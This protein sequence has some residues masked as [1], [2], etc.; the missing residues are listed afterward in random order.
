[1]SSRGPAGAAKPAYCKKIKNK[2]KR[3]KHLK[4]VSR[5]LSLKATIAAEIIPR[6]AARDK[7]QQLRGAAG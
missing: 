1:M 2:N 7:T 6:P 3:A 4:S 5:S